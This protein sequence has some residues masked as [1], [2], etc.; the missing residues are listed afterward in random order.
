MKQRNRNIDKSSCNNVTAILFQ[1]IVFISLNKRN[2]R[3]Q[4]IIPDIFQK[5][6]ASIYERFD[7]AFGPSNFFH[8]VRM[9]KE[10]NRTDKKITK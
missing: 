8:V 1:M 9:E 3:Q 10:V 7:L 2:T 6:V 5:Q 4:I